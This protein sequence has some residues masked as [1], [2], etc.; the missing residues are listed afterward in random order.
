MAD[1]GS[2]RVA[3]TLPSHFDECKEIQDLYDPK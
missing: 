1:D 3:D 2:G